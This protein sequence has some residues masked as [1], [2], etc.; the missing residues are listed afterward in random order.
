[1]LAQ[2]RLKFLPWYDFVYVMPIIMSAT[3]IQS[4]LGAVEM[5][6]ELVNRGRGKEIELLVQQGDLGL[7]YNWEEEA[8]IAVQSIVR[9]GEEP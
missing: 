5:E 3:E 1:M 4:W 6:F 2:A 9:N 8:C 7:S